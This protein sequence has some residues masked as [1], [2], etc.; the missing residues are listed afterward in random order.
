MT[1][2]WGGSP[3]E[4][5]IALLLTAALILL[6]LPSMTFSLGGPVQPPVD[7][8]T[9]YSATIAWGPRRADPVRAYDTASGELIFNVYDTLISMGEDATNYLGTWDTF[10]SYWAFEPSLATN[11]PTR[12]EVIMIFP[13]TGINPTDPTSYWFESTPPDGHFYHIEGWVDNNPDGVLGSCDV[14][15]VGEYLAS[16]Q[17]IQEALTI[18]TWNVVGFTP[19][20]S[21]TVHRYYYDFNIRTSPVIEFVDNTGA[22]VDTFEINDAEY[23][24]ERGLVQDQYGS[25]MWMFYKPLFDQMNSDWLEGGG[26]LNTTASWFLALLIKDAIEVMPA[27]NALRINVA[28]A[29]PD[30]AFKQI[31]AQTWG[32]ILSKEWCVGK[33][34]WNGLFQDVAPADGIVDFYTQWRHVAL[35]PIQPIA[36][37]NYAGTGPYRVTTASQASNLVIMEKNVGYWKG[38]PAAGRKSSLDVVQID[39]VSAWTT[40]KPL[41]ES[42]SFDVNAV[43]RSNMIELLDAFGEPANPTIKTVKNISPALAMDA[44]FYTFELDPATPAMFTGVFPTGIPYD[45]MKNVHVRNAF[46]YAWNHTKHLVEAWMGE[47]I[48]R[49]TPGVLG[50]V[51]DYYTKGPDPPWKFD[52]NLA[53]VEAELKLA[54]FTQGAETKSVWDWGGFKCSIYGNAGNVPRELATQSIKAAFDAL[55]AASGKS[56]VIDVQAP[57]WTTFL[58]Y[59]EGHIMPWWGIGW[60]ADFADADNWY[61]PYMHTYG[62][63][64]YYQ[65]YPAGTLGPRTGLDK[66]VLIDL[67]VKTPDSPARANMYADLDDIYLIDNP[68]LPI[69][70]ALGRRWCKYWVKGWYYN[71]LYPSQYYYHLYKEDACWADVNGPTNGIPDVKVDMRD[72]SYIAQHFGAKAPDPSRPVP[73]DNKWAP[74]NYGNAGCDVYGDRKVDMKDVAFSAVHFGHKN[75]P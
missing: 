67:A 50:L 57:D 75:V 44:I 53:M 3:R 46:S 30:M 18:R 22:V 51:P 42:G 12:Q 55:S 74:G 24:L 64:A 31:L 9:L 16:M 37:G 68:S 7:T 66:D 52:Y 23:S 11:V 36:V 69:I 6:V 2:V 58:G 60:L 72:V 8:T 38:W 49:E 10:E 39:Y 15:Y 65:V 29:Y 21:V 63:F 13:D 56:F 40:R 25:P 33:G 27:G 47:G 48:V 17:S 19:G 32:S 20:V 35:S 26:L 1:I 34:C 70:Q 62:D 45:F 41:F 4:K 54:M 43:P 61:R 14:I 59:M 5:S 28:T 73:Y 71:G